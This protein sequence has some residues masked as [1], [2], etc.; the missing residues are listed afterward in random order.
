MAELGEENNVSGV[1]GGVQFGGEG[2]Q[3]VQQAGTI[4]NNDLPVKQGFWSKFKAF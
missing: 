2:Q 4:R 3:G 1:F